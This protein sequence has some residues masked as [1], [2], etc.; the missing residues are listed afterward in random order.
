MARELGIGEDKLDKTNITEITLTPRKI[1]RD[2]GGTHPY[3]I[4][5]ALSIKST[6][7]FTAKFWVKNPGES[8]YITQ[9]DAKNYRKGSTVEKTTKAMIGSTI[10]VDG[11]TYVLDGW[12]PENESGE[13]CGN[14]RITSW[15]YTPSEKELADGTVNFYAHYSPTATS[16][17]LKK[18]VTGNMG[19]RTKKFHFTISIT[20]ENENVTFKV[21][22]TSEN[23]SATVD[24]A[25]DEESNLTEIPVGAKVT[26]T[27]D[28]YTGSRYTTSYVIDNENSVTNRE[29]NIQVAK[30]HVSAHEIVF[31]NNKE[32]IPDTGITLDSLP[33]ITL[34]AL[35]IAGGIFYL[36]CRYKKRFV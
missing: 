9:V 20:K 28:N 36:I 30:D 18:L 8:E 29:A 14:D 19:D 22:N 12:Y 10:V 31:T 6:K 3:H 15:S 23:G 33:F 17:K 24:L 27:E 16:I 1:S 4:D 21:G 25:N 32:A 7:I 26:I 34:L 5:C 11:V 35:S 2:N 13:A